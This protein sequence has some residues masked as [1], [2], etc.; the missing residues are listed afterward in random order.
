[1]RIP[2]EQDALMDCPLWDNHRRS[3]NWCASISL[4]PRSPG[5]IRRAFWER[6][7]GNDYYYFVPDGLKL[8]TP[9]E[10]GSDYYTASGRKSP[11]RRYYTVKEISEDSITID[12]HE[13]AREACEAAERYQTA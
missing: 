1:M 6:A 10:F 12:R 3:R 9:L 13:N 5:G 7:K 2:I 4:D 11:S 8:G